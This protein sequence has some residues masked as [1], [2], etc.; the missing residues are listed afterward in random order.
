MKGHIRTVRVDEFDEWMRFLEKSYG[1]SVGL[2]QRAYPH[3]YRPT[4]K[5]CENGWVIERQGRIVSHVG[6]YPIE[7][8]TA[9]VHLTVGGIGGVATQPAERGQGHMSRLLHHI[10]DVMR[11]RG[12]P[13]SWLGGDRQRYNAFGWETAGSAFRLC[14]SQRSLERA[15][16]EPIEIE[17]RLPGDAVETIR[18]FQSLPLCHVQRPDLDRQIC[19]QGLRVWVA[20]DGYAILSGEERRHLSI[21]ELVSA[22]GREALM[23]RALL[24]WT[25]GQDASWELSAWDAD[26]LARLVPVASNWRSG[27]WQMYRIVD[28]GRLLTLAQPA[29]EPRAAAVRDLDLCVGIREHDRVDEA[30]IR[31]QDGEVSVLPGRHTQQCVELSPSEAARLLLGGAPAATAADIPAGLAALLPLPVHVPALDHV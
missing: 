13:L 19:R 4:A 14:F 10:I 15:G 9:G 18:R 11:D 5:L 28:L 22:S 23:I 7:T 16:V 12:Y 26:R 17:E 6:L 8:V 31:V 2:F 21:M 25:F 20:E 29:M 1:H 24:D 27:G 30:T 3:L